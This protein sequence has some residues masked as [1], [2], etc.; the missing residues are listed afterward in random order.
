MKLSDLHD[1]HDSYWL[2]VEESIGT[3]GALILIWLL[4]AIPVLVFFI[5]VFATIYLTFHDCF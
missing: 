4:K 2:C 5:L 1:E 3:I